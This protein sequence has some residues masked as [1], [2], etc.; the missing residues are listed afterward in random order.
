PGL[1]K[2]LR[3]DILQKFENVVA[4]PSD[5]G[6]YIYH[7]NAQY[8]RQLIEMQESSV[9][10]FIH[11]MLCSGRAGFAISKQTGIQVASEKGPLWSLTNNICPLNTSQK[12][13]QL[14]LRQEHYSTTPEV[15]GLVLFTDDLRFSTLIDSQ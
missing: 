11:Q 9:G 1:V 12:T 7:C 13:V 8:P 15:W 4:D 5:V 10:L 2:R 3:P 6:N 14:L